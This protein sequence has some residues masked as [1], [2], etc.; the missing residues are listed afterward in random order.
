MTAAGAAAVGH[1]KSSERARGQ[2]A[3]RGKDLDSASCEQISTQ[4][5]QDSEPALRI[6]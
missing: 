2:E 4:R 1:G 6:V 3:S 5:G